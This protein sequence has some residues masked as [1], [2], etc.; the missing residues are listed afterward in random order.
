MTNGPLPT[1]GSSIGSPLSSRAVTPCAL[2][3][4]MRVVE[5]QEWTEHRSQVRVGEERSNRE[6]VAYPVPIDA[7][8]DAAQLLEGKFL[9][10]WLH[11]SCP[12]LRER[13]ASGLGRSSSAS[14]TTCS[15]G[16]APVGPDDA[17][18]YQ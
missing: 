11:G 10:L 14:T 17:N 5:Q 15:H 1:M 2:S 16:I 7:A 9:F 12:R 8:L 13:D 18:L 6:P 3:M 4:Q